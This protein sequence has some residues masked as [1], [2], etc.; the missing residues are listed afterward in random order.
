MRLGLV[1]YNLARDWDIPTIIERCRK[2]G[3]E[4]VELRTTHAHGV[5]STLSDAERRRVREQ[6]TDSGVR[7]V[8]LGSAFEYHAVDPEEVRRNVEG[9]KD[10]ARLAHDVGAV[11]VKVRPNGLNVAAGVPR[12]QTLAQ[13]G[14][15]LRECGEFAQGVGVGIW[16]E[17]H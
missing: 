11:G 8:S 7:L 17:V 14:R 5:E 6:F 10:Y 3:F 9:T 13:I 1:T 4:G 15:A 12:E 16:L 2:T